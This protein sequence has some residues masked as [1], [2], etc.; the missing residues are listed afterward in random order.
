MQAQMVST[1]AAM[2]NQGLMWTKMVMD[3][4]QKEREENERRR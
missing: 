1:M 2:T 4:D 3:G